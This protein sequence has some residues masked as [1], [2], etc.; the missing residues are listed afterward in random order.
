ML[1]DDRSPKRG[2]RARLMSRGPE[3]DVDD[4]IEYHLERR[5]A[6]YVAQGMDPA[7]ARERAMHRFGH[8]SGV[9][10]EAVRVERAFARRERAGEFLGAAIRDARVAMRSI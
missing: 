5:I 8:V 2:L 6:E 3:R 7:V 4:E 9:R 10:A 1:R